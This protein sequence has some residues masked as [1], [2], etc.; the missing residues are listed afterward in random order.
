MF[1]FNFPIS[2]GFEVDASDGSQ[3]VYVTCT[4]KDLEN[5]RMLERLFN[6]VVGGFETISSGN[7]AR[8][9]CQLHQKDDRDATEGDRGNTIA[10][11]FIRV[12]NVASQLFPHATVSSQAS[13]A[14]ENLVPTG[15]LYLSR[16]EDLETLLPKPEEGDSSVSVFYQ[17]FD[18]A[19]LEKFQ[20]S[21]EERERAI[22]GAYV[23]LNEAI[24]ED[25]KKVEEFKARQDVKISSEASEASHS[26]PKVFPASKKETQGVFS[27]ISRLFVRFWNWFSAFFR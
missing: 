22:E 21:E 1:N 8:I 6:E 11:A 19:E 5:A 27:H 14:L 2:I 4:V 26:L 23:S 13:S 16:F 7:K 9:F 12:I 18:K 15:D 25:N 3:R 10:D 20:L 24:E 17:K